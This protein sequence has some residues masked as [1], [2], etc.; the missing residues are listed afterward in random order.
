MVGFIEDFKIKRYNQDLEC[1]CKDQLS[2]FDLDEENDKKKSNSFSFH[3]VLIQ[4]A[5]E[6]K[7]IIKKQTSNIPILSTNNNNNDS[8]NNEV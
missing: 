7:Q 6:K 8:S 1:S 5:R 2:D 4:I 3:S